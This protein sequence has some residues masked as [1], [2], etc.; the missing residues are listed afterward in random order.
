MEIKN[1]EGFSAAHL[2]NEVAKGGRFVY[3]QYTI[4]FIVVTLKRTSG[5]YLVRSHEN[6]MA[7]SFPYTLLSFLFGWW[8]I[9]WGPK[10]TMEAIQSNLRGGKDV[11]D[12]VMAVVAGYVLY[13]ETEAKRRA[14]L[15]F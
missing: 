9:P 8:G 4:S 2:Q 11:T 14:E 3:F 10:C 13:E 12:D 15:S 5:V 6:A 1:I 7:R